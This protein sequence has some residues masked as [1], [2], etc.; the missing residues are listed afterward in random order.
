MHYY[1]S[2][3]R[4]LHVDGWFFHNSIYYYNREMAY[5]PVAPAS[6]YYSLTIN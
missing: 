6:I 2:W 1:L 4:L 5:E 3:D